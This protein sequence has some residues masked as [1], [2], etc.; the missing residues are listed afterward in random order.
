MFFKKNWRTLVLFGATGTLILDFCLNMPWVSKSGWVPHLCTSLPACNKFCRFTPGATPADLLMASLAAKTFL[1]H[2][3]TCTSIGRT[4]TQ[5]PFYGT[6]CTLT[7]WAM[8]VRLSILWSLPMVSVNNVLNL[9]TAYLLA[10]LL[11][12][13]QWVSAKDWQ[14]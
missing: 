4:W 14:R 7:I 5:D 2:I 9:L 10:M 12:S 8:L 1:I 3:Y 11:S 6:E 13:S